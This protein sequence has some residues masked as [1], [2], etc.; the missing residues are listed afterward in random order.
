M[1]IFLAFAIGV[2]MGILLC[3]IAKKK[4]GRL[5]I[6]DND[7]FVAIATKPEDLT[8]RRWINLKVIVRERA[9]E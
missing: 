8:K 1:E 6:D 7:Y 4:D 2:V 9:R 3:T 5:V